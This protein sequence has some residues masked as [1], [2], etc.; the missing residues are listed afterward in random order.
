MK[1]ALPAPQKARSPTSSPIEDDVPD[2]AAKTTMSTR[3]TSMVRFAPNRAANIPVSS[4]T[5]TCTKM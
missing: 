2:S 4:I 5:K 3:P 1:K